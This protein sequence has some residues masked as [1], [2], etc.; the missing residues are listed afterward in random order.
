MCYVKNVDCTER[1]FNIIKNIFQLQF[2]LFVE[3][4][5]MQK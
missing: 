5:K 4:R 3:K 2:K 1:Y